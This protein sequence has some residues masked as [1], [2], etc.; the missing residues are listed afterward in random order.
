MVL[1]SPGFDP[2]SQVSSRDPAFE[3]TNLGFSLVWPCKSTR[4]RKPITSLSSLRKV[5][6]ETS[7]ITGIWMSSGVLLSGLC[8]E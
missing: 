2:V 8:L 5:E 1:V 6:V 3:K 7:V 4:E